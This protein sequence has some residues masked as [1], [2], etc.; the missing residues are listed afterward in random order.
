MFN[1]WKKNEW[2]SKTSRWNFHQHS[3]FKPIETRC[4][5]DML[6]AFSLWTK[7]KS[8]YDP[9]E[10]AGRATKLYSCEEIDFC[11]R[12]KGAATQIH[13]DVNL[14]PEAATPCI[15]HVIQPRQILWRESELPWELHQRPQHL[16]LSISDHFHFPSQHSL[17]N[18]KMDTL[19]TQYSQPMFEKEQYSQDDQMDLYQAAPSLSLRFAMPPIAQVCIDLSCGPYYTALPAISFYFELLLIHSPFT[20]LSVAPRSNRRQ[21]QPWLPYQDRTRYYNISIQ[22]SRRYHSSDRFEGYGRQLDCQSNSQEG[23]WD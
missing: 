12:Q 13:T 10:V 6:T 4:S 16:L 8:E 21:C 22:I 9:I 14:L 1:I 5:K 11:R 23:H 17:T 7:M 20:A 18:L 3:V 2:T 15:F 19:V